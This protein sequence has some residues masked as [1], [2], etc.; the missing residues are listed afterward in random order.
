MGAGGRCRSVLLAIGVGGSHKEIEPLN[1]LS[2]FK[3][4]H[5][6]LSLLFQVLLAASF[7]TLFSKLPSDIFLGEEEEMLALQTLVLY[8]PFKPGELW[9]VTHY[10]PCCQSIHCSEAECNLIGN[11]PNSELQISHYKIKAER[12]KKK[13]FSL[14]HIYTNTQT[15]LATLELVLFD[16]LILLYF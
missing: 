4:F 16:F 6:S 15:I 3:S 14:T 1:L 11:N 13:N 2:A 8:L 5:S 7:K 12:R 9:P 10:R